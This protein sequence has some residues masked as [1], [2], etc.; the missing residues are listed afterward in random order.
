[1]EM[2]DSEGDTDVVEVLDV[3][4]EDEAKGRSKE[5]T[6]TG[7]DEDLPELDE[8]EEVEE[9]EL[10]ESEEG[11]NSQVSAQTSSIAFWS[12][13]LALAKTDLNKHTARLTKDMRE[14]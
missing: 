13:M 6:E 7:E 4:V 14:G 5:G 2:E 3:V 12:F 8:L 1:M 9:D 11:I 10:E